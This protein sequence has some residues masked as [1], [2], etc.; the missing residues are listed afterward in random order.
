MKRESIMAEGN[1]GSLN[2]MGE[3]LL[4]EGGSRIMLDSSVTQ[5]MSMLKNLVGKGMSKIGGKSKAKKQKQIREGD[6]VS[7][8]NRGKSLRTEGESEETISEICRRNKSK[9]GREM[10]IISASKTHMMEAERKENSRKGLGR[11]EKKRMVKKLVAKNRPDVLFWSEGLIS[12]LREDFIE[13]DEC[14]E[15]RDFIIIIG[16]VNQFDRRCGFVNVYAPNEERARRS[17]WCELT[18]IMIGRELMW[19]LGRDFNTVQNEQERIESGEIGRSA[20]AFGDF[21]DSM[22]LVDLPLTGG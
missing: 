6:E 9:V 10:K 8:K 5:S 12:I 14:I 18:D 19:C 11:A 21:I 2:L 20:K 7:H 15:N 13:V 4:K 1:R 22:A 17:L 3:D 16:K